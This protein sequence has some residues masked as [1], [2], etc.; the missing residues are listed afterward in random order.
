MEGERGREGRGRGD[1][2][3]RE[4]LGGKGKG[5]ERVGKKGVEGKFRG[6]RPPQMFFPR[7]A[8]ACRAYNSLLRCNQAHTLV[9]KNQAVH[10]LV[11]YEVSSKV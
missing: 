3:G 9:S 1:R 11:G 10:N 2:D 4:S 5:R 8:P 7:T 6:S